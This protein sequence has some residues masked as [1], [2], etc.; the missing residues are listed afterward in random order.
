MESSL[1]EIKNNIRKTIRGNAET[2]LNRIYAWG[3]MWRT[4]SMRC[5]VH[6]QHLTTGFY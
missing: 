5:K 1:E 4:A 3:E 2:Q 6:R